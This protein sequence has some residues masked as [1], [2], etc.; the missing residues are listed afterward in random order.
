MKIT[1]HTL[2]VTSR[3]KTPLNTPVWLFLLK[4]PIVVFA[5]NIAIGKGLAAAVLK[6]ANAAP[7]S[8]PPTKCI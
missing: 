3:L 7:I 2:G 6:W 1:Q 5:A 8:G 4:P